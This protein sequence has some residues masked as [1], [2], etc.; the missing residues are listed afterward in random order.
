VGSS[1]GA[2]E[3]AVRA[4]AADRSST[5]V[6]RRGGRYP[7]AAHDILD[8]LRFTEVDLFTRADNVHPCEEIDRSA[9][10]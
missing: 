9:N 1:D 10:C 2:T 7:R 8:L 6:Y 5:V 3:L 4:G